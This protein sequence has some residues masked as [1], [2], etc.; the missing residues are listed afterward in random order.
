MNHMNATAT[1]KDDFGLMPTALNL[2]SLVIL[3][4]PHLLIEIGI[5]AILPCQ[6]ASPKI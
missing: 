2:E 5:D 6:A 1:A 3:T 4:V